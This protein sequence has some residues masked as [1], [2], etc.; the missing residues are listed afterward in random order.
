MFAL[1][2]NFYYMPLIY[3]ITHFPYAHIW[4]WRVNGKISRNYSFINYPLDLWKNSSYARSFSS[5]KQCTDH[6]FS[7]SKAF[8]TYYISSALNSFKKSNKSEKL[9]DTIMISKDTIQSNNSHALRASYLSTFHSHIEKYR[10]ST[11]GVSQKI[12]V[13]KL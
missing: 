7:F 4:I 2:Y 5:W 1:L 12:S 13:I 6:F 3:R 9:A 8:F 11:K 10:Y